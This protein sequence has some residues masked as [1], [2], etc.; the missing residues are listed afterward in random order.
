MRC[1]PSTR[2]SRMIPRSWAMALALMAMRMATAVTANHTTHRPLKSPGRERIRPKFIELTYQPPKKIDNFLKTR[3][4]LI[5]DEDEQGDN[6]TE[7]NPESVF[8]HPV[9]QRPS[10]QR[11]ETVEQ[12]V[13]AVEQWH[14]E[15]IDQP[16][17]D[18]QPGQEPEHVGNPALGRL[19]GHLSDA[20]RAAELVGRARAGDDLADRLQSPDR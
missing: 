10:P 16:E 4:I 15:E 13:P 18:R 11:L 8:H 3:K 20:D 14:R 12:K 1:T 17:V 5:G 7:A 19:A 9:R 2:I 6:E